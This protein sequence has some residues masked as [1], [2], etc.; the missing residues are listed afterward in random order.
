M[1]TSTFSPTILKELF[2]FLVVKTLVF[3]LKQEHYDPTVKSSTE[4]L[5]SVNRQL[6]TY[7]SRCLS[8]YCKDTWNG[9]LYPPIGMLYRFTKLQ[10]LKL[11]YFL[12]DNTIVDKSRRQNKIN[13]RNELYFQQGRNCCWKRRNCWLQGPSP[14]PAMFSKDLYLQVKK[15]RGC[16]VKG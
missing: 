2:I 14:F 5:D 16:L 6:N 1:V 12:P 15:N 10:I 7:Y 4:E 9:K 13:L 11:F 8:V 3:S